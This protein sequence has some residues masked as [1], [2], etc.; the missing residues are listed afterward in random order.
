MPEPATITI[1][2][3]VVTLAAGRY[4]ASVCPSRGAELCSLTYRE[5]YR[6]GEAPPSPG[7]ELLHRALD[8]SQPPA[9]EWYGHGQLLFP[10]VGRHRD[11]RYAWEGET[12]PMP[13]HGLAMGA[14][15]SAPEALV[16]GA[17]VCSFRCVATEAALP[18]DAA[19]ASYPFPFTLS[20]TFTLSHERG[21]T[22][23][24][25]LT[26][27]RP[28]G[29]LPFAL[30][31]HL[32]FKAPLSGAGVDLALDVPA[33]KRLEE[34]RA[35][36]VRRCTLRGTVAAQLELAPGSLLSGVA[37]PAPAFASKEG[38]SLDAPGATDGVFAVGDG[39]WLALEEAG[40]P[41]VRVAQRL[42]PP[43]AGGGGA[44]CDWARLA[45]EAALM[46]LWGA[47]PG[48]PEAGGGD[49]DGFLC[50]E[51]WLGGPDALNGAAAALAPGETCAWEFHV[52][53]AGAGAEAWPPVQ[54]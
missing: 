30:G 7:L 50:V 48:A 44:A 17:G 43:A 12:R 22:V 49:K 45:R 28:A 53:C 3:D 8:F 21:L 25:E 13:L 23:R 41:R 18:A 42:L 51:P 36:W 33:E 16:A 14:R 38:A 1:S 37:A 27:R 34:K 39:G 52:D 4:T 2:G 11:G 9:P 6:E 54:W 19:A 46:V 26:S 10:A 5:A 31:S 20:I 35:R 24:H 40:A 15:F 32:S 47:P 29:A